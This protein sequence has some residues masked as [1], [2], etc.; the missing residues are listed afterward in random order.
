MIEKKKNNTLL[1]LA[2]F[3]KYYYCVKTCSIQIM[4]FIL[5][6]EKKEIAFYQNPTDIFNI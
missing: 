2:I 3:F 4:K 6:W 1:Y 5:L